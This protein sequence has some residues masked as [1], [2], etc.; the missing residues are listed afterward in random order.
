MKNGE[1]GFGTLRV[2]AIMVRVVISYDG[3]NKN[4]YYLQLDI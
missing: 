1:G 4:K 2:R 3:K